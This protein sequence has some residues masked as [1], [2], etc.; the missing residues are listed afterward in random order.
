[1]HKIIKTT[2]INVL[3]AIFILFGVTTDVFAQSSSSNYKLEES[4]FGTG[5]E[6]DASSTNYRSQQSAG[7]LGVGRYA[8]NSYDFEAGF[9]TQNTPFLELVVT[10]NALD[11]G[12]LS[13]ATTS[14]GSPT[15]GTCGCSWY[16]RTYLSESYVLINASPNPPEASNGVFLAPKSTLGAPSSSTSVEEFGFNLVAN[17]APASFGA[18]PTN[19]P[20]NSFADGQ[21]ASGYNTPNQFKFGAGDIIAQS[22]ATPGNPAIGQTDYTIS[23]I[24]KKSSITPAGEYILRHDIVVVATF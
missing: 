6:V 5:G 1:M 21:A 9:V 20:D 17:T 12:E 8:S 3:V 22:Q 14:Y 19:Q 18:N 4:Y 16:V 23:Y 13:D 2:S 10:D 11:L 24:A 7:A 15:G